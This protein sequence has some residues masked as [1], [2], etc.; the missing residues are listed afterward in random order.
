MDAYFEWLEIKGNAGERT[1]SLEDMSDI[2]TTIND[3]VKHFK[4]QYL[5]SFPETL[6]VDLGTNTPVDKTRLLK[7][8]KEFYRARG[9][10]KSYQL[11]MR[12][13]FDVSTSFYYPRKDILEVSSGKWYEPKTIK[14]S[15]SNDTNIFD[16]IGTTIKQNV[17]GTIVG[18]G[19]VEEIITTDTNKTTLAEMFL[20][21]INGAFQGGK[22]VT[23][24]IGG[25]TGDISETIYP[26]V[27]SISAAT[28]GKFFEI[29][30]V[31][32]ATGLTGGEGARGIVS[33]VDS[34]G[35][36]LS[37]V[38]SNF[39]VS[40]TGTAGITFTAETYKG[41][42]ASFE[43]A[44]GTLCEYPGYYLNND[45]KLNSNKKIRDNYFYQ[46]FSYQLKTQI[47]LNEY[48]QSVL[49]LIHPAG[50]KL[51]GS[52]VISASHG[53]TSARMTTATGKEI[54]ILGHYTPYRFSTSENLR[55]NTKGFDLY[56][57]GYNGMTFG[58]QVSEASAE[59]YAGTSAE[60]WITLD[61]AP[62]AGNTITITDGNGLSK[63]YLGGGANSATNGRFKA[64]GTPA[65][66]L[67]GLKN[68]INHAN[69]HNGTIVVG[70]VYDTPG[71]SITAS[72]KLQQGFGG[73]SGNTEIGVCGGFG[74]PV[75]K[76]SDGS[77]GVIYYESA[78]GPSGSAPLGFTG[79][80]GTLSS[81][82]PRYRL[83]YGD[84]YRQMQSR[85]GPSGISSDLVYGISSATH[86]FRTIHGGPASIAAQESPKGTIGSSGETWDSGITGPMFFGARLVEGVT[87]L[88]YGGTAEYG[89]ATKGATVEP[90][91]F[92][93]T[94]QAPY[95]VI[96]P[97]PNTRGLYTISGNA[98][99][100]GTSM[101]AVPIN[102]FLYIENNTIGGFSQG[103][104]VT[105]ARQVNF[106]TN[107][108]IGY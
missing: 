75:A 55:F 76:D 24:S 54:S 9:T 69:G 21:N 6:A 44:V 59:A 48:K 32:K 33:S 102:P 12:V 98:V 5:N 8:I 96:F 57:F 100:L 17:G 105:A 95:W 84:A 35:S 50:L 14:I 34:R 87:G 52:L 40:Y 1:Y 63:T 89:F 49:D 68:A 79:G 65:Q 80:G 106:M 13:L 82:E 71:D 81:V 26:V 73:A 78:Y 20:S 103:D 64:T 88:T 41:E 7:R 56:P 2:D 16:S 72:V 62:G 74:F 42:G 18:S 104:P 43:A 30:D 77:E 101:A 37:V 86:G 45:G 27:T 85:T 93:K 99:G 46:E 19:K 58:G 39:G 67:S 11:L 92:G 60:A 97:H 36:I 51:F 31:I 22:E 61:N 29:G 70:T 3:F 15:Y 83:Y 94:G 4:N 23:I 108:R 10:E 28:A 90:G 47:A 53:M 66:A 38:M 91:D 107:G 25:V